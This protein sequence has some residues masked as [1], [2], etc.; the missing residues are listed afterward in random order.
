[1]ITVSQIPEAYKLAEEHRSLSNLLN[2][3]LANR[4]TTR[5]GFFIG[6]YDAEG[7]WG[8]L[9]SLPDN[10]VDLVLR[11]RLEHVK[12]SLLALGVQP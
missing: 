1:M 5:P 6:F 2:G 3:G 12:R 9:G 11:D 7:S 10:V 8:S 4:I